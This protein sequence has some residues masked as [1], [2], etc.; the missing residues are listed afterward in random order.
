LLTCCSGALYGARTNSEQ[1]VSIKLHHVATFA[2][3]PFGGNPA[4]VI[5]TEV[6]LPEQTLQRLASELHADILTEVS[7]SPES[8]RLRFASRDGMTSPTGHTAHAAAHV[9]LSGATADAVEF[10]LPG[11][12]RLV[13]HLKDGSP[14]VAWPVL[15]WRETSI[16]EEIE[17]CIG[18]APQLCLISSFG[19]LAVL[20]SADEVVGVRPDADRIAALDA[21]TLTV[22]APHDD[23]DFCVRVFAPKEG[24]PEDPVCGTVHRILAPFW[25]ARLG[26]RSLRS[27]QLSARGG[28][29]T[30]E[31][32]GD[33]VLLG[34]PAYEFLEGKIELDQASL[35]TPLG[36]RAG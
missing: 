25:A 28:V 3:T 13:A 15:D 33:S 31:M 7:G 10:E 35:H 20:R 26:K 1:I 17:A 24:L 11:G 36:S 29:L 12:R 8:P 23:A 6:A 18:I 34:G 5:E 2:T 27:L 22:T 4:T 32:L 19:L 30:C 9:A 21:A 14:A 16:G